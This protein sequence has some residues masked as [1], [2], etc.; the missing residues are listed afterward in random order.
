MKSR[1]IT[2]DRAAYRALAISWASLSQGS[3]SK[4]HEAVQWSAEVAGANTRRELDRARE[5]YQHRAWTDA[6]QAFLRAD[7]ETPLAAE[8]LERLAMAAYL[9]GR[10]ADYLNTLERAYNAHRDAHGHRR[11]V[12]CAFWLGFRLL[13]RGEIGPR[14]RLVLPRSASA[15]A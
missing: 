7:Q 15:R 6:Y 14:D 4:A 13:M 11:A 2:A 9:V 8:D 10:D 1:P 12:R 3:W 5:H